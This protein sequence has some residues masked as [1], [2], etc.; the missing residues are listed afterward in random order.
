MTTKLF[1]KIYSITV[2][3]RPMNKYIHFWIPWRRK[4]SL[5]I[6]KRKTWRRLRRYMML[7]ISGTHSQFQRQP[8]QSTMLIMTS[9]LMLSRKLVILEKNHLTSHLDFTGATLI[10]KTMRSARRF[11]IF[12]L[13]T[14][15]RT[16]KTCSD[17]IIQ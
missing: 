3:N 2:V 11:T 1:C 15:L 4:S 9:L 14:T 8:I 7:M 17:L 12:L 13:K 5:D 16:M 6:I 10:L